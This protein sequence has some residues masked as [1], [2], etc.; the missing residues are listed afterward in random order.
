MKKIIYLIIFVTLLAF[1]VHS[2][3][4]DISSAS[5]TSSLKTI[6]QENRQAVI[7][8]VQDQRVNNLKE[9]GEK[10]IDRRITALN[11]L[12]TRLSKIKKITDSQRSDLTSKV[13]SEID[14]LTT[15][16]GKIDA[17]TDLI[18]LKTDVKSIVDSYRV[19]VVFMPQIQLLAAT[20][21][22]FILSAD[23]ST[24]STKLQSRIN[25]AQSLGKDI[26]QV[27]LWLTDLNSKVIEINTLANSINTEVLGLTPQGYPD[28][29]TTILDAKSKLK[30]AREDLN[31]ARI[32]AVN[33]IKQ[34]RAWGNSPTELTPTPT[35]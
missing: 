16:R 35:P 28:N 24:L 25:N 20:D 19:F 30:A 15:L 17:D 3:A 13:Q 10:E 27:N 1:P 34:L 7:S 5:P 18:T 33:I 21:R 29:K 9:R 22:L 6:R 12:I 14:T 11:G 2:N 26:T 8:K 32:D 23:L 4:Q 31:N